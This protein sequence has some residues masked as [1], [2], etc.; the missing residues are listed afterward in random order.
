M[1]LRIRTPP[2]RRSMSSSFAARETFIVLESHVQL[3]DQAAR[4]YERDPNPALPGQTDVDR[5]AGAVRRL[6]RLGPPDQ[7][8][9]H[10]SRALL[11]ERGAGAAVREHARIIA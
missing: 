8:R 11:A 6:R 4:E 5:P 10:Q 9:G 2:A 3:V 1:P 7:R